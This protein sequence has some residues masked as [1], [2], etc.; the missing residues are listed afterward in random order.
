MGSVAISVATHHTI[1]L[2]PL[3]QQAWKQLNGI[4]KAGQASVPSLL[5]QL[6][7]NFSAGCWLGHGEK[8]E[9]TALAALISVSL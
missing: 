5:L 6:H 3:L 4:S 1:P 8:R 7:S 9:K 2:L